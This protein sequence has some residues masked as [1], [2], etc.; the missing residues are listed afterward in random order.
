MG[1]KLEYRL[2]YGSEKKSNTLPSAAQ[3]FQQF[4]AVLLQGG[5]KLSKIV[6]PSSIQIVLK[7]YSNRFFE[8]STIFL[9]K[10][11]FKTIRIQFE[12]DFMR[13]GGNLLARAVS[14]LASRPG[15]IQIILK[16]CFSL[17]K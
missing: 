6:G 4:S 1:C 15:S 12:Y 16:S 2:E 11:D 17:R 8:E 7:S 10:Y 5:L 9:R 14:T 13:C 3:Q